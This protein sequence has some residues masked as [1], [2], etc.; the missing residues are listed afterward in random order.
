MV[1]IMGIL[2]VEYHPL[3]PIEATKVMVAMVGLISHPRQSHSLLTFQ[4]TTDI[5]QGLTPQVLQYLHQ[6]NPM[7]LHHISEECEILKF[8]LYMMR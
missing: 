3:H 4:I 6:S 1:V 2:P 7:A 8:I 5:L